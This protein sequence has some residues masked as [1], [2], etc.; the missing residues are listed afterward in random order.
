MQIRNGGLIAIIFC[1]GGGPLSCDFFE[2]WVFSGMDGG[3]VIELPGLA[4]GGVSEVFYGVYFGYASRLYGG[5]WVLRVVW[6]G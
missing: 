6:L 2:W 4:I 5:G 3:W 1:V